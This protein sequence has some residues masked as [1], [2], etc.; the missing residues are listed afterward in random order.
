M[1]GGAIGSKLAAMGILRGVTGI[2]ILR[3]A[4]EYV[5]DVTGRALDVGMLAAERK[6][7]L[8]VIEANILPGAGIMARAALLAKLSV[9]HIP[10]GMACK[11]VRCCTFIAAVDMTGGTGH[12]LM[13]VK[14]WK[15]SLAVIELDVLP[16][17]RVMAAGAIPSHLPIVDICMTR[18]TIAGCTLEG[19]VFV[20]IPTCH[21]AVLTNQWESGF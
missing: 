18:C 3:R 4:F 16:I 2:T 1:A 17:A 8:V 14:Q 19:L 5:I 6:T 7:G 10:A 21:T 13:A 20:A 11:A 15:T 12:T 9:V